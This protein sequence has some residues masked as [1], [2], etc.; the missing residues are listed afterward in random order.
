M[1]GAQISTKKEDP[2]RKEEA[3]GFCQQ[4]NIIDLNVKELIHFF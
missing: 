3:E 4:R 2:S 1:K